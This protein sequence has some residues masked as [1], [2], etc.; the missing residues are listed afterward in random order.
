MTDIAVM[1]HRPD[2]MPLEF[3]RP[4]TTDLSTADARHLQFWRRGMYRVDDH[5]HAQYSECSNRTAEHL[6]FTKT[7]YCTG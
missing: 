7:D 2:A 5:L 3:R 6:S 4:L 1:K